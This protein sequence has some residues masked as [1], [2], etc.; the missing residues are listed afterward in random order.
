M[1]AI[2]RHWTLMSQLHPLCIVTLHFLTYF[3][4]FFHV[5]QGASSF[6]ALQLNVSV[7]GSS[8]PCMLHAPRHF[9]RIHTHVYATMRTHVAV[10]VPVARAYFRAR[11]FGYISRQCRSGAKFIFFSNITQHSL[12]LLL[13]PAVLL[14]NFNSF[15]FLL[16][17]ASCIIYFQNRVLEFFL[18]LLNCR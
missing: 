7:H 6:P 10:L 12:L 8:H 13:G 11:V 3:A 15:Q 17:F 1:S 2:A 18:S 5:F 14:S 16:H 4:I 9:P